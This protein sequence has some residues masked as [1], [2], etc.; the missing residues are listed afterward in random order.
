MWASGFIVLLVACQ[1]NATAPDSTMPT[2]HETSTTQQIGK[3]TQSDFT[4]PP[5]AVSKWSAPESPFPFPPTSEGDWSAVSRSELLHLYREAY[6]PDYSGQV[7]IHLEAGHYVVNSKKGA[8]DSRKRAFHL[9]PFARESRVP[10]VV[11]TP[12]DST[13]G[14]RARR[15]SLRQIG[16][17]LYDILRVERPSNV[18]ASKLDIPD[19]EY[20]GVIVLVFDALPYVFWEQY[21]GR[22]PNFSQLRAE[23]R[24][25]INTWLG[26]MPS[27]TTPS[28]AVIGTG[29]PPSQTGIPLNRTRTDD[30]RF[31]EVFQGDKPDRLIVPTVADLYDLQTQNKAKILGF[32]SQSRA[33]IAMVGH[34]KSFEG[35]DADYSMWLREHKHELQTNPDYYAELPAYLNTISAEDYRGL[36][37]SPTFLHHT[38]ENDYDLFTSPHNAI[39]GEEVV[40]K[41]MAEDGFGDDAVTDLIFFNQKLLDNLGH[42]YGIETEEYRTG[43]HAMDDF[44]GRFLQDLDRQFG[45]DYLLFF[46]SDHG[47]GPITSLENERRHSRQALLK[48]I[49]KWFGMSVTTGFLDNNIY[50]DTATLNALGY[51]HKDVCNY[52]LQYESSWVIDCLTEEEIAMEH[53]P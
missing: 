26:Q 6:H 31:D 39:I 27:N 25:Y 40:R 37:D 12:N 16:A 47:F 38:I 19:K 22:L 21:L 7:I 52:L 36:L 51:A 8:G 5:Y 43:M 4:L 14:V 46:T 20:K 17:S 53:L 28:H 49:D 2:A 50:V 32:C 34:G 45:E 13:P 33:T 35:G 29:V 24:E 23:G 30:N 11:Y 15:V 42:R 9:S 3:T 1:Q 41:V 44:I 48:G 10:L 18:T